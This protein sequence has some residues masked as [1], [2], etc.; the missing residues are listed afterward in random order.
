M[1]QGAVL[2][3]LVMILVAYATVSCD[4][5]K[6]PWQPPMPTTDAAPQAQQPP[7]TKQQEPGTPVVR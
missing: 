3:V 7:A 6:P 1:K 4:R 2:M 5:L